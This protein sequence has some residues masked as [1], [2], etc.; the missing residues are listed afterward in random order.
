MTRRWRRAVLADALNGQFADAL[1]E[2][3]TRAEVEALRRRA[4]TLLAD[5]VMPTEPASSHSV[6]AFRSGCIVGDTESVSGAY[7]V[8]D[9]ALAADL[10]ADAGELL[11]K[12]REEIG[13]A[14]HGRSATRATAWPTNYCCGGCGPS[15][16][17]TRCSAKRHTTIWF[18]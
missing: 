16:R 17:V 6:P 5:P 10:A 18:G 1:A 15:V 7:D 14:I 12:V 4:R 9:A 2:Q 3:I 8:T 11:L 13:F